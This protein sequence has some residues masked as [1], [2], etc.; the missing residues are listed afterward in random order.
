MDKS[1]D[2]KKKKKIL[3]APEVLE[4]MALWSTMHLYS[5]VLCTEYKLLR[6]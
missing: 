6:K 4:P 1:T 3:R 2:D 5:T